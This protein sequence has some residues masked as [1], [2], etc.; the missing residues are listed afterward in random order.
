M[1]RPPRP[2]ARC[3]KNLC[4]HGQPYCPT[5]QEKRAAQDI[6]ERGTPADRGIDEAWRR[7][8]A[9]HVTAHP[10]CAPCLE[11]G[12]HTPVQIV[13]HVIEHRGD[14]ALRLA[15]TNLVSMCRSCHQAEHARRGLPG[16]RVPR[17]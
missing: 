9:A 10:W 8:R 16:Y 12:V 1:P 6:R 7:V 15:P 3:R 2:C 4:P 11:R 17:G 13:H 14:D 5:C